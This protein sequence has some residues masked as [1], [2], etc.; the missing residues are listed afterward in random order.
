VPDWLIDLFAKY[1]YAAVFVGLLMENAGIPVPGETTLL[2][3]A[4]FARFG[5]LSF[6]GVVATAIAGA[7][8]GDN[9]G[10]WIGRKGGRALVERYGAVVGITHARLEGFD[11][12]FARHGP[13]TVFF[14]RFVT[15]FR[16]VGAILAGGSRLH[17]W[18]FL[19]YNFAGAVVWATAV[20]AA[21]YGLAYSWDTLQRIIGT[22]GLIALVVAVA[23]VVIAVL[24]LRREGSR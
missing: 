6:L 16:V 5:R 15:G 20:G 24:R 9:I 1:G 10:F 19:V 13:K 7:T 2:A 23:G 12:F 14:A 8:L 4:A 3:G 17:W 18:T 22:G 11:R 21:G